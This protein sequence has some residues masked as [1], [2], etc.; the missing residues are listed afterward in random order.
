MSTINTAEASPVLVFGKAI[1]LGYSSSNY[2][3]S[4][5]N[6]YPKCPRDPDRLVQYLNNHNGGFFRFFNGINT[7]NKNSYINGQPMIEAKI[8]NK[9]V[10]YLP[11]LIQSSLPQSINSNNEIIQFPALI[12][13][14]NDDY[15]ENN[16]YYRS[17]KSI[18]FPSDS[19]LNSDINNSIRQPKRL[20]LNF[21]YYYYN[22]N[23]NN[24]DLYFPK[25][26]N[27]Q[28]VPM[29][30]P[31]RTG[32]GDLR[33]DLEELTGNNYYGINKNVIKFNANLT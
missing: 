28:A 9:P 13:N 19:S 3:E 20:P 22:S 32:T 33:L 8:Q 26:P 27:H 4:C 31:D 23:D 2:P 10:E 6:S 24:E 1:L 7:Q 30:F 14:I 21:N 29:I 16:H 18:R 25:A 11:D 5:L 12:E 15:F 17:S